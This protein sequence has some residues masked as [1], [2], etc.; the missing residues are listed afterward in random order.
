M[1]NALDFYLGPVEEYAV[2]GTANDPETITV[3][4]QLRSKFQ[5]NR[6]IAFHDPST[7]APPVEVP[8][9]HEKPM[10]DGRVTTYICRDF[11]CQAP[12]VG[13]TS[14]DPTLRAP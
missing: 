13:I 12:V 3:L 9:L 14:I 11:A 4:N 5:P 2:I 6:V 1:L 8:L 10:V 7:G